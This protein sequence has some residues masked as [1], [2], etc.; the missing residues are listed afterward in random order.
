MSQEKV[1][2]RNQ[3]V[4]RFVAAFEDDDDSFRNALHPEIEWFP[5]EDNH[6]PSYGIDGAMRIRN[7]WLDAWD[8]MQANVEGVADHGESVVLSLH[9]TGRG[10][11]SGVEVDVRLYLHFK[12]RDDRVVYVFEYEDKAAALEAAG[13]SE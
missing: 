4:R 2:I 11:G 8:D 10:K 3:A 12:V 7:H 5:F 13:L 9:V 6:T 1:E